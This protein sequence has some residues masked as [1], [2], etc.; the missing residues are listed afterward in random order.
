MPFLTHEQWSEP[1]ED[2]V[3]W[4][5][6]DLGKFLDLLVDTSLPF[7]QAKMMEDPY[8]GQLSTLSRMRP[9]ISDPSGENVREASE[10]E[11]KILMAPLKPVW[12]QLPETTFLS[13]WYWSE[14]ES[15]AMWRLYSDANKGVAVVTTWQA[16]KS[17]LN[18]NFTV[19]GGRVTYADYGTERVPFNL[20]TVYG[21]KRDSFSHEKEVRLVVQD[22]T[23]L[24]PDRKH[25][26]NYADAG[27]EGPLAEA[28]KSGGVLKLSMDLD[29]LVKHVYVS[30]EAPSW[31]VPIVQDLCRKYGHDWL[32]QQSGLYDKN[33][34]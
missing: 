26:E 6:M 33:L 3:L 20:V 11:A 17:A 2:A 24:H 31:W 19:H 12:D 34:L 13:C 28:Q 29:V 4:R 7:P 8:E 16:L 30:P 23:N 25:Q 14:R 1:P 9:L 27:P 15:A 32:V 10:E 5:Y 21:Y 18:T 22:L